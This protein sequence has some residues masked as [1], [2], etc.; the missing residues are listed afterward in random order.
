MKHTLLAGAAALI[1]TACGDT[2]EADL[3]KAHDGGIETAVETVETVETAPTSETSAT[4]SVAAD[5]QAV[6]DGEA[7]V[8]VVLEEVGAAIDPETL[9]EAL[10]ETD[11][12]EKLKEAAGEVMADPEAVVDVDL[13]SVGEVDLP[14]V[15]DVDLPSVG[16][17]DLP[18]VGDVD[19]PS[20]GDVD[21]PSVGDAVEGVGVPSGADITDTVT[22]IVEEKVE[23]VKDGVV[24]KVTEEVVEATEQ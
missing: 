19:L 3:D 12:M 24:E 2:T 6:V 17:V 8:E 22:E 10:P 18:S 9:S 14:S 4:E 20:V 13:P 15:G 16:D 7:D 5:I 21:L 11:G 1:L 23:D